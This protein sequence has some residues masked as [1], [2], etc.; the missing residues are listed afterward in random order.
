MN[1]KNTRLVSFVVAL[2]AAAVLSL[3]SASAAVLTIAWN[4]NSSNE[5]GFAIERAPGLVVGTAGTFVEV[6]RVAA[7]V[8]TYVDATLA[9]DSAYSYRVRAFNAGGFSGYT[10]T[11]SGTT[12]PAPPANP[13]NNTVTPPPPVVNVS[14][15]AG[16]SITVKHSPLPTKP[17]S[18]TYNIAPPK[19]LLVSLK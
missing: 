10:N 8:T 15:S 14:L 16:Q 5:V 19:T 2:V 6:G 18:K 11:A 12:L 13:T 3:S 1:T 9:N 17:G 4:D 7:G